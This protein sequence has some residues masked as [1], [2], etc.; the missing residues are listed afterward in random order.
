M[1]AVLVSVLI[2]LDGFHR[3][4]RP[5]WRYWEPSPQPGHWT[6]INLVGASPLGTLFEGHRWT[7]YSNVRFFAGAVKLCIPEA[8]RM[9]DMNA[10]DWDN[11]DGNGDKA[12]DVTVKRIGEFE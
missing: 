4:D 9:V 5:R 8:K 2:V 11:V 1:Y 6:T 12:C 10:D 3:S 7:T